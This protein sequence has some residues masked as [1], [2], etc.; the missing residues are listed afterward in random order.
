MR[1]GKAKTKTPRSFVR[2]DLV[3]SRDS[4]ERSVPFPIKE[5]S[6]RLATSS[7]FSKRPTRKEPFQV[8]LLLPPTRAPLTKKPTGFADP[9]PSSRM[10]THVHQ[11]ASIPVEQVEE[12]TLCDGLV[13]TPWPLP[14]SAGRYSSK[15]TEESHL[16]SRRSSLE[17]PAPSGAVEQ[18]LAIFRQRATGARREK[19]WVRTRIVI[20]RPGIPG[21]GHYRPELP[22]PGVPVRGHCRPKFPTRLPTGWNRRR[23]ILLWNTPRKLWCCSGNPR[24]IFR[25]VPLRRLSSTACHILARSSL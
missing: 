20:P 17:L 19:P 25:S 6:T 14:R 5:E 7:P 8:G 16:S 15:S 23:W 12:S 24:P 2:L 1:C 9:A 11:A 18:L 10:L 3:F 13:V 4:S 21:R 22:R